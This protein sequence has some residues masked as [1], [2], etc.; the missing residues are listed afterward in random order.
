M[1]FTN[2]S[3]LLL[4]STSFT[5]FLSLL[6]TIFIFAPFLP[7]AFPISFSS[8]IKITFSLTMQ[9]LTFAPVTDSKSAIRLMDSESYFIL[10]TCLH[11]FKQSQD[12]YG[13]RLPANHRSEE[14]T[15]ELQ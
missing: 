14:H 6:S 12:R 1:F 9:S 3:R 2:W 4:N 8:M 11:L 13:E 15:S 10:L 5:F 7:M